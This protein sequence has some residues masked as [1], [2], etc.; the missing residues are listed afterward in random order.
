MFL[1]HQLV[2]G[3]IPPITN[4]K[5]EKRAAETLPTHLSGWLCVDFFNLEGFF[6]PFSSSTHV[7][8]GPALIGDAPVTT[9]EFLLAEKFVTTSVK[10]H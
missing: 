7:F 4:G 9:E 6:C 1:F 8:T 2:S 3:Q 10:V 5:T